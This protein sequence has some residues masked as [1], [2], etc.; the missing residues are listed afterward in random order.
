MTIRS[1]SW[2][3]LPGV[4]G[5][6]WTTE[7]PHAYTLMLDDWTYENDDGWELEVSHLDVTVVYEPGEG[8]VY[9]VTVCYAAPA[10]VPTEHL[11][12]VTA[13][14]VRRAMVLA[15]ETMPGLRYIGDHASSWL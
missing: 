10:S 14:T 13:K 7:K 6:V 2:H 5:M 15:V 4:V 8:P 3:G 9:E 1:L 12:E 11:V